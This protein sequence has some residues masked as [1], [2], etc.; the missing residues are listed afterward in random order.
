MTMTAQRTLAFAL[1][2]SAL[3]ANPALAQRFGSRSNS[4]VSLAGNEAVQKEI[5]VTGEVAAK[6][7]TLNDESR[8]ASQKEFTAMGLDYSAIS[9]LPALERAAEMRKVS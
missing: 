4:L 2:L 5:G 8:N 7:E 6:L 3:S 1:L 9:D